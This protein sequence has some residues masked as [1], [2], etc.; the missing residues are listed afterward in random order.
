M[1]AAGESDTETSRYPPRGHLVPNYAWICVSNSERR[2]SFF[3][4]KASEMS[5]KVSLKGR[6]H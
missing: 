5:E 2:G 6:T 4:L 1:V 3:G